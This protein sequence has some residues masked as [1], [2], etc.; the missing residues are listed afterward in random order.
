MKGRK[1]NSSIEIVC[2]KQVKEYWEREADQV[3]FVPRHTMSDGAISSGNPENR[4]RALKRLRQANILVVDEAHRFLRPMTSRTQS[5][6]G[7]QADFL[8]LSTATPLS[9]HPRDIVRMVEL[10]GVDVLPDEQL[11][12]FQ[13][14]RKELQRSSSG[15]KLEKTKDLKLLRDYLKHLLV[16]RTKEGINAHL[17][18]HPVKHK[19]ISDKF[20]SYP[21]QQD[22]PYSTACRASDVLLTE[23]IFELAKNMKGLVYL[24]KLNK[25]KFWGSTTEHQQLEHRLAAAKGIANYQVHALLRSSRAALLEHIIGTEAACE[26]LTF[27]HRKLTKTGNMVRELNLMR[28]ALPECDLEPETIREYEW[29]ND[30][31]AYQREC[32]KELGIYAAI[33]KYLIQMSGD[34]EMRKAEE[35]QKLCRNF[36]HVIAFDTSLIT[37]DYLL[38]KYLKDDRHFTCYIPRSKS[39]QDE[40]KE[41][42]GL[43]NHT[44]GRH[45]A[46]LSDS[47]SEGVNLPRAQVVLMLDQPSVLRLAEQ[48]I[49][50]IDRLN[51]PYETIH[52]Y[53]PGDKPPFVLDKDIRLFKANA[54]AR[55]LY[56]ANIKVLEP[57]SY[58]YESDAQ[59]SAADGAAFINAFREAEQ[60]DVT[61]DASADAFAPV[62]NLY[63]PETGLISSLKYDSMKRIQVKVKT[64][65]SVGE[66]A[67]PWFF[68]ALRATANLPP[69]W[70][71]LEEE[72]TG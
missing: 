42:F 5:I 21:K 47:M 62:R 60:A 72:A 59:D 8:I 20:C 34:R 9:K 6:K 24:K 70:Y 50:R 14:L 40:V 33:V 13:K 38:D 3:R 71:L 1:F 18:Q 11:E 30:L 69:R 55:Y 7:N 48:R 32:D 26:K 25:D 63:H 4:A 16:R 68:V 22:I 37:L 17:M 10:F 46:L 36:T 56:G 61:G 65:L 19:I 58:V 44:A 2:P 28:G 31:T 12:A 57:E 51:S 15:S 29:L 53:W 35:L 54:A 64:K 41:V 39:G 43:E 66:G 45:L 49:G 27:N 23:K 67:S 52:V